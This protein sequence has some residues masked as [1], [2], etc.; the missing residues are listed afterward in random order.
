MVKRS[1]WVK[2]VL[3]AL[4]KRS[5]VWL[6]GVRRSGKTSLCNSMR[7]IKI[8]DC[9]LPRVREEVNDAENFFRNLKDGDIIALDEVHRLHNPSEV[10]K[11]AADHYP[12]IK[13]IATGSS[14]MS[15]REKFQD[16]L[17]GR[18]LNV[19]LTPMN[20]QDF[21]DFNGRT[22][23]HRM[24]FGGLPNFFMSKEF[25]EM[26]I[27]EWLDS[28]WAKDVNELFKVDK[29]AAFL[30]MLEII[31]LQSGGIFESSNVGKKCGI[32]HTTSANY[33]QVMES[34]SVAH[35]VRPFSNNKINELVK[36][37][38][39][40]AFDTG[41]LCYFKGW[42]S[43]RDDDKGVLWEHLVLNEFLSSSGA[44]IL[45]YWR[46]KQGNEVD[47]IIT[48]RG[49]KPIAIECK[50]REKNFTP[51]GIKK[52]RQFYPDGENILVCSD[53]DKQKMK[54][55]KD[56]EVKVI[57]IQH[58]NDFVAGINIPLA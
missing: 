51:D 15:A 45:K 17:T 37:P 44:Q 30:K 7:E 22:I 2:R 52:F 12:K 14:T 43:L 31:F 27:N 25:P 24:K 53:C 4:N 32:S 55:V 21:L 39:V 20:H 35:I 49:G 13:I 58:I 46:T 54:K 56:L 48:P 3:S 40:Y 28:F 42:D 5:V 18:K 29:R 26:E 34:L 1:F 10:L 57:G 47:F 19:F 33:L 8:F 50:Y 23:E 6:H 16:T 11:I 9:E 36:A 41:F 38:K